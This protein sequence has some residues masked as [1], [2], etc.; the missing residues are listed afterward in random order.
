MI[1]HIN[2]LQPNDVIV[3][4]ANEDE[5]W[6][7]HNLTFDTSEFFTGQWFVYGTIDN[8]GYVEVPIEGNTVEVA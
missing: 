2:D 5:G 4:P 8:V 1:K 7:S 3:L 6:P